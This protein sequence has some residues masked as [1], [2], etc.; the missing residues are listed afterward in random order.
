MFSFVNLPSKPMF[1]SF[2]SIRFL[3]AAIFIL[4]WSGSLAAQNT[5]SRPP[6]V[7][8]AWSIYVFSSVSD[9][10]SA[11]CA[12]A[13]G[14]LDRVEPIG[15]GE[16]PSY[17]VYCTFP[18][19]FGGPGTFKMNYVLQKGVFCSAGFNLSASEDECIGDSD[20]HDSS[21]DN[22]SCDITGNPIHIGLGEKVQEE[23]DY[24][25]QGQSPLRFRRYYNSGSFNSESEYSFGGQWGHNYDRRII[26]GSLESPI[27]NGLRYWKIIDGR[28]VPFYGYTNSIDLPEIPPNYAYVK[29]ANGK[30]LYH[31]FINGGW[32]TDYG[33]ESTLT[34]LPDNQGWLFTTENNTK[35]FYDISGRLTAIEKINGQIQTLLY[36]TRGAF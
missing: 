14:S 25:P 11:S 33:V 29:R 23:E 8:F 1:R 16:N 31:R 21:N 6:V 27:S 17:E 10:A 28:R 20:N 18:T 32:Q 35:E 22:T 7:G 34:F 15:E 13:N 26:S 24:F 5:V 19:P 9:A 2:Y 36:E 12:P 30:S 4:L 3:L